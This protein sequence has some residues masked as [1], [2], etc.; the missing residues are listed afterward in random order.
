MTSS[1]GTLKQDNC[2]IISRP[3]IST[4]SA[5][6]IVLEYSQKMGATLQHRSGPPSL[7]G[8]CWTSTNLMSVLRKK[9][10]STLNWVGYGQTQYLQLIIVC[11]YRIEPALDE[12]ED[13]LV[14]WRPWRLQFPRFWRLARKIPLRC[15]H[16][17]SGRKSFQLEGLLFKKKEAQLVRREY[18]QSMQF[19]LKDNI[20][21]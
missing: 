19:F 17:H 6:K 1:C 2:H 12:S 8:D 4:R 16:Q 18:V 14:W 20:E 7:R 21:L 9:M 5:L 3:K 13:P 15:S 11:K 10:N